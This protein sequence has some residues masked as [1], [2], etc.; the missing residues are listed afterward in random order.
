MTCGSSLTRPRMTRLPLSSWM[1][2]M[3]GRSVL[4]SLRG[5]HGAVPPPIR[6][7]KQKIFYLRLLPAAA[8]TMGPAE[9]LLKTNIEFRS[10]YKHCEQPGKVMTSVPNAR[11]WWALTAKDCNYWYHFG[12][13]TASVTTAFVQKQLQRCWPKRVRYN[14]TEVLG[15]V[16]FLGANLSRKRNWLGSNISK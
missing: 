2:R 16:Q 1:R 15:K 8:F 10:C 3:S 13:H 4:P 6:T 9:F 7:N 5:E 11:I 12:H 14:T